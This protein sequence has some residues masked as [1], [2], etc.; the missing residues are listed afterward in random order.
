MQG[1]TP[2]WELGEKSEFRE[3]F[4]EQVKVIWNGVLQ[5]DIL[6]LVRGW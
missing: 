6:E 3:G 2:T 1:G 4:P 5:K